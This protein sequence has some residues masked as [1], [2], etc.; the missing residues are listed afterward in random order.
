[1]KK[2]RLCAI[3]AVILAA[4][5][6]GGITAYLND[7]DTRTDTVTLSSNLEIQLLQ[8]S[9]K[10]ESLANVRPR[11]KF[12]KDPQVL[13]RSSYDVYAFI[14]VTQPYAKDLVAQDAAGRPINADNPGGALYKYEILDGWTQLIA[15]TLSDD[16]A[17]NLRASFVYAW[18]KDG[19]LMPLHPGEKTGPLFKQVE[20]VNFTK[21]TLGERQDL[22]VGAYALDASVLQ[23]TDPNAPRTPQSMWALLRNTYPTPTPAP[24]ATPDPSASAGVSPS[25]SP[26]ASVQPTEVSEGAAS[27]Q[28]A[29]EGAVAVSNGAASAAQ[30]SN[31]TAEPA[32]TYPAIEWYPVPEEDATAQ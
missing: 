24:T 9:W 14:E 13:N 4:V 28:T 15:P 18:M 25:P 29:A 7:S 16:G 21:A 3:A 11:Q 31:A 2:W 8:P 19:A 17:G 23:D 22:T 20:V 32:K 1:M 27:G 30:A 26:S 12:D 10:G 5:L 6:I